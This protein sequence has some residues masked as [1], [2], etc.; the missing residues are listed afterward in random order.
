MTERETFY[1]TIAG[2][3]AAWGLIRWVFCGSC[4]KYRPA[5]IRDGSCKRVAV[6]WSDNKEI[7]MFESKPDPQLE[8]LKT[9]I[10][11]LVSVNRSL[12]KKLEEQMV[13]LNTLGRFVKENSS[14]T[15]AFS[16]TR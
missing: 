12:L 7:T 11:E 8:T 9:Q 1:D 6:A 2:F 5:Q 4:R 3:R 10:A 16:R 13:T 14:S 15:A